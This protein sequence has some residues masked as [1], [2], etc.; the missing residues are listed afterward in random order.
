MIPLWYRRV[1]QEGDTGPDVVIVRRKLGLVPD[2]PF[3]RSVIE[4]VR[5]MT[6]D[7]TAIVDEVVA[8]LIGESEANKA[9]L[10]PEWFVRPLERHDI[11]EDVRALRRILDV[12][13]DNRFEHDL[14]D[15]VRRFQSAH[16][17]V[18]DGK[19]DERLARLLGDA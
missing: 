5:G 9:G 13:D 14:E 11:G 1:I 16:D 18:P 12:W 15:A 10:L 3:D 17:L 8:T 7:K 6:N 2:G 4:R 19:V